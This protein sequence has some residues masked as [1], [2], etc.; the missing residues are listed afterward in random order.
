MS[1]GNV[2]QHV[3]RFGAFV[4]RL[5]IAF[6]EPYQRARDFEHGAQVHTGWLQLGLEDLEKKR[7]EVEE[8]YADPGAHLVVLE[9]GRRLFSDP[10]TQVGMQAWLTKPSDATPPFP[11]PYGAIAERL[12]DLAYEMYVETGLSLETLADQLPESAHF[13]PDG[14]HVLL[15]PYSPW[16][17]AYAARKEEVG[18]GGKPLLDHADVLFKEYMNRRQFLADLALAGTLRRHRLLPEPG[19]VTVED[20]KRFG[21]RTVGGL[22]EGNLWWDAILAQMKSRER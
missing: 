12:R 20:A 21:V 22:F 6:G 13:L 4:E 2:Y 10:A 18:P 11:P 9:D 1:R 14:W 7:Q 17:I 15:H 5:I 8:F 3:D 16:H 19:H